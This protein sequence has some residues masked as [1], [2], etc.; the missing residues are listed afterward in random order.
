M[1]CSRGPGLSWLADDGNYLP[2]LPFLM[3]KPPKDDENAMKVISKFVRDGIKLIFSLFYKAE[4]TIILSVIL[5]QYI[6]YIHLEC[7]HA[8]AVVLFRI[9]FFL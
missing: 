7:S 1:H 3:T 8:V 5:K 4:N 9:C 6:T 2:D